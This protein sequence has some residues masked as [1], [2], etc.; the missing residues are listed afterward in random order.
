MNS[1]GKETGIPES[2]QAQESQRRE[3]MRLLGQI[4]TSP[5]LPHDFK[6][7]FMEGLGEK[8]S[9]EVTAEILRERRK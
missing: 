8:I 3:I 5:F 2:S 7:G 1:D 6:D 9:L 4:V